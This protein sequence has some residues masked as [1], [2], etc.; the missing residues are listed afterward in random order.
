MVAITQRVYQ[1][2]KSTEYVKDFLSYSRTLLT[3]TE[4][5]EREK[6]R[7]IEKKKILAIRRRKKEKRYRKL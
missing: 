5:R 4:D 2:R 7:K 6:D 1:A 3:K